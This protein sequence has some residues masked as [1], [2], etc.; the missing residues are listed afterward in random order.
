MLLLSDG[1][2]MCQY[3]GGSNWCRLTPDVH[4]SYVNGGWSSL[5]PMHWTRL[6]Y[7]STVL[8]NGMV[9]V[10][11]G[12]YGTG[13]TNSEVYDPVSDTWTVVP[14][15]SGLINTDNRSD[16]NSDSGDG[17]N[18]AGF[19]DAISKIL[20]NGDVLVSPVEPAIYGGTVIYR[21]SSNA[22]AAG[23][24]LFRGFDQAEAS[25]VK[26]PDD[27]ILTIDRL[28]ASSERYIPALNAWVNDANVPVAMY[29]VLS[30]MG[31]GFLLA[32]GQAFFLGG[33]G[34][35]ALYTPSGTTNAGL[36]VAGPVIPDG[37][38]IQDA[39]AAMMVN[40][41]ILCAFGTISNYFAPTHFFEY[42]PV[43]N[44][45]SRV[46]GPT[47]TTDPVP[48]YKATLLDL[49]D[50][51][52][53]YSHEGSDLYVYQPSDSPLPAGQPAIQSI[54][55][56]GDGSFTLSGTL[57][58]GISEGAAYGDDKQMNSNYPLVRLADSMG[59]VYYARTYN[60]NSTSVMASGRVV[61]TR[62]ALPAGL[63]A[64][65]YSLLV[66]ANGNGSAPVPFSVPFTA[67]SILPASGFSSTGYA[68]GPFGI[69]N[70][71]LTL[72]TSGSTLPRWS[73]VNTC[74]WLTV[75]PP[76]GG[77]TSGETATTVVASL[78]AAAYALP[79]GEWA[80]TVCFSNLDDSTVQTRQFTLAVQSPNIVL[81][82]GFEA[83]DFT[84][85]N[86]SGNVNDTTVASS[87]GVHSGTYT[88]AL[89][90]SGALGYLAQALP[91]TP[92]QVYLL[93]LWLDSP[94]GRGPNEFLVSWDGRT[95]F[96]Q[97]DIGPIGWTNL[98]YLVRGTSAGALLQIGF[99]DDPAYLYLDDISLTPLAAPAFQ[100]IAPTGNS[101]TLTWTALP[102][103]IYQAQYCTDL[104]QNHWALLGYP[105]TATSNVAS[106]SDSV[107]PNRQRFY[108][109]SL[110]V[111]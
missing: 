87:P 54:S 105:I 32:N 82:G 34:N 60:W 66:S 80:G 108:R 51:S 23:P 48:S 20:P 100:S 25:W 56:S 26:L 61:T 103:G 11:G 77:T 89:G 14:L 24:A 57:F 79:S 2:V 74:A 92:G 12:E 5:A 70:Q 35:T 93:S 53:L 91:T 104:A 106:L 46:D 88:A 62:F 68:G 38:G 6:Y 69:S 111:P 18:F 15:P 86:Q 17:E 65:R 107:G 71:T 45:F 95:L 52:V 43:A 102:G 75:Q 37:L 8:T 9:L 72:A 21:A 63:P 101:V 19:M 85:W 16:P 47:G 67:L 59:E 78:T 31:P 44:S 22:W 90:P 3:S 64:G 97:L 98:Q 27:S 29:S 81:N 33:S 10:A 4:G 83:S 39:P 30:E 41:R 1:T 55:M 94:D 7:S 96:D 28:G 50:G 109:V 76:D 110:F 40:G 58:N 42:D 99:R 36:W 49:P 13:S 84:A 73:L